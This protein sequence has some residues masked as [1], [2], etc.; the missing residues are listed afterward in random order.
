MGGFP[1]T[2]S[3]KEKVTAKEIHYVVN[4]FSGCSIHSLTFIVHDDTSAHP[5]PASSRLTAQCWIMNVCGMTQITADDAEDCMP[6][7]EVRAWFPS[8]RKPKDGRT[9]NDV[10][11]LKGNNCFL[12]KSTLGEC[13][14]IST[15]A[16]LLEPYANKNLIQ[17]TMFS[18]AYVAFLNII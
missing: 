5:R 1:R 3:R 11:V 18:G 13:V 15:S 8:L 6:A 17:D 16:L 4:H 9:H 10:T 14:Y 12:Q 7:C 2:Q